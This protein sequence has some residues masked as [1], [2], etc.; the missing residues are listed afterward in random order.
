M[1]DNVRMEWYIVGAILLALAA[2]V[3]VVL[4]SILHSFVF[5]CIRLVDGVRTAVFRALGRALN[6]DANRVINFDQPEEN[7][8]LLVQV[9]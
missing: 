6:A 8:R 2:N 4:L 3:L 7:A 5:F 1:W 9:A